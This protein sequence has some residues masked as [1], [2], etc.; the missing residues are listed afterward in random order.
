M[1]GM[2]FTHSQVSYY[3]ES[4]FL[5][6]SQTTNDV[7][8]SRR[9]NGRCKF[10]SNAEH[11]AALGDHYCPHR[12]HKPTHNVRVNIVFASTITCFCFNQRVSQ[13]LTKFPYLFPLRCADMLKSKS[14]LAAVENKIRHPPGSLCLHRGEPSKNDI[15]VPSCV[16]PGQS[17]F[18]SDPLPQPSHMRLCVQGTHS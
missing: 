2:A 3:G 17:K 1:P 5:G 10:L 9:R 8:R 13:M 4:T 6:F 11:F 14:V 15:I 7:V 18:F 16:T 12:G